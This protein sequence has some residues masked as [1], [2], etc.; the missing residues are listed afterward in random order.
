MVR[1]FFHQQ[2]VQAKSTWQVEKNDFM[3]N[4]QKQMKFGTSANL[5]GRMISSSFSGEICHSF[6]MPKTSFKESKKN[7]TSR[8]T[9]QESNELWWCNRWKIKMVGSP[10][11]LFYTINWGKIPPKV[12]IPRGIHSGKLT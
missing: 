11:P 4:Y 5:G 12:V 10:T 3:T 2:F 8:E 6:I 9:N 7:T 1:N